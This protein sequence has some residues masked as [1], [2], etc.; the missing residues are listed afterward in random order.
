[1]LDFERYIE[2]IRLQPQAAESFRK[3]HVRSDDAAFAQKLAESF[4]AYDEGDEVFGAFLK[5]FAES[6]GVTPEEMN[7]YVYLRLSERTWERYQPRRIGEDVFYETMFSM[8]VC[9]QVCYENTGI[10]GIDQNVYRRWQRYVLDGTLFRLGRLEFQLKE[11]DYDVEVEGER[12]PAGTTLLS[13]H[14]PR[15]LPLDEGECEKSYAWARAFFR[16]HY[17]MEKCVFICGSWLLHPWMQEVLPESSA[18]IRFQKKFHIYRVEQ[19]V[20]SAVNWIF[21]R[22][23]D[24]DISQYPADTSLRRAAIQRIREGGTIGVAFGIR[25]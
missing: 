4:Q 6:E 23:G 1:M 25:L 17:G 16:E 15:Y 10:Y 20:A 18:I 22:C 24:K 3:I 14:I 12:I 5:D 8:T 7:L 13:V 19:N 11:L 9:T 21:P 2:K